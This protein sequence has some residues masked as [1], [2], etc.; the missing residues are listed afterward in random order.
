MISHEDMP[1]SESFSEE[2]GD[3]NNLLGTVNPFASGGERTSRS[4][5]KI[6]LESG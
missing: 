2:D 3:S 5:L 6:I 4:L 1:G